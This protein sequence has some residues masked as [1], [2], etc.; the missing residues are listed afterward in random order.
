[1]L[2]KYMYENRKFW[3]SFLYQTESNR[4]I[5]NI[6]NIFLIFFTTNARIKRT[7]FLHRQGHPSSGIHHCLRSLSQE[8]QLHWAP[9]LGWSRQN[10]NQY[11]SF[12]LGN[13]LAPINDDWIYTRVASLA[14]KIYLRPHSG[15]RLLS[16]LYGGLHRGKC[17]SEFHDHASTKII[18]WGLQQL[19]KQKLI[20]KDKKG[21]S[22]KLNSRIL[23]SEGRRVL[24]RIAT[25][26]IKS[27]KWWNISL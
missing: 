18:R 12:Q 11:I 21:D 14:R 6:N 2:A 4:Y 9:R 25:E 10:R 20:K 1:M 17:R 3:S 27:K 5:F 24:N 22:L 8:E 26:Y 19:E 16:H 13:E 15:V 23:S 7:N